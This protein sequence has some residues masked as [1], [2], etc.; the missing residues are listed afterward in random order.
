MASETAATG[1]P[2]GAAM[3]GPDRA[4][5]GG[6]DRAVTGGPDRAV[7]GGP[8]RAGTT[9]PD[10]V[11]AIIDQWRGQRPDLDLEAMAIIGR[12]GRLML[13]ARREVDAVFLARGLQR[14][15]FDVLAALR[16]AGAPFEASPS[17]LADGLMLSRAGM[18]GRLDR[19]EAAGLVRRAADAGDRRAIRVALTD[20]G[21]ALIDDLVSE[22]TANEARLLA[23]LDPADRAALDRI[24][25][26]LL[27]SLDPEETAGH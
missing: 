21:R 11:D 22:H 3:N 27:T 26:T 6:P 1:G 12:L 18:T 14:G 19:L 15:E 8:D 2:D 7:T 9:R 4:V 10:R 13:V 24:T 17:A 16:R 5:T 25:R 23:V 20:A